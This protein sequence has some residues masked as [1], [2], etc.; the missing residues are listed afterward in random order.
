MMGLT[1]VDT[2]SRKF[3]SQPIASAFELTEL[4]LTLIIFAGLPL[5]TARR[6]HVQVE[7]IER[8]LSTGVRR[9]SDLVID[10]VT[11]GVLA[12]LAWQLWIKAVEQVGYGD[13]TSVLQIA[14]A[15]VTYAMAVLAGAAALASLANMV[16][17]ART[18]GAVADAARMSDS[19]G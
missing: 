8:L 17:A 6:G 3:L 14:L 7:L 15:P 19:G 4:T 12:V 11:A 16:L 13:T 18:G 2:F 9:G 5:V 1:V 10:L